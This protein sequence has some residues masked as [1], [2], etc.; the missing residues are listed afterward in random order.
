MV[1]SFGRNDR[2]PGQ[3]HE[4]EETGKRKTPSPTNTLLSEDNR[5]SLEKQLLSP[6]KLQ[7]RPLQLSHFLPMC[8]SGRMVKTETHSNHTDQVNITPGNFWRTQEAETAGP[9]PRSLEEDTEEGSPRTT[10]A[11]PENPL[12]MVPGMGSGGFPWRPKPFCLDFLTRKLKY[13]YSSTATF[14]GIG[15]CLLS[16]SLS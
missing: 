7:A 3:A 12:R 5:T 13:L 11:Q 8:S 14:T 10:D 9:A 15:V 1:C 16:V 6:E 2:C 4:P